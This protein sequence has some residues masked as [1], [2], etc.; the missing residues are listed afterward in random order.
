MSTKHVP[1][2]PSSA[3]RNSLPAPTSS[4]IGRTHELEQLLVLLARTRL[5]TLVGAGGIGK[6]RLAQRVAA[7]VHGR[8]ENGVWL[9]P[10]VGGRD[11][12]L[13]KH[14]AERLQAGGA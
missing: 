14:G 1:I 4:F 13:L 8:Y 2:A 3:A 6:S 10:V 5:L 11:A 9:V 12:S 7:E